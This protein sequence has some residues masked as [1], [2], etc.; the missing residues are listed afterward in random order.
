MPGVRGVQFLTSSLHGKEL[1]RTF[2]VHVCMPRCY[3]QVVMSPSGGAVLRECIGSTGYDVM[4]V[5]G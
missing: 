2:C 4:Y 3:V 5:L 1:S